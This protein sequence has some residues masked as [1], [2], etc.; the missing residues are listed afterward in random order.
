MVM[1]PTQMEDGPGTPGERRSKRLNQG[2]IGARSRVG[3]TA[4][5]SGLGSQRCASTTSLSGTA[6][7]WEKDQVVGGHL[8][9]HG[10]AFSTSFSSLPV[11]MK[12]SST[13]MAQP[14][15]GGS[16]DQGFTKLPDAAKKED[17]EKEERG[18]GTPKLKKRESV[19]GGSLIKK[20][21]PSWLLKSPSRNFGKQKDKDGKNLQ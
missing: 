11:G 4:D 9:Q 3:S 5:E 10:A 20:G 2:V 15:R 6:E 16:F 13:P 19:T 21:T 14:D 1:N 7:A 12:A 8:P 17:L 18:S